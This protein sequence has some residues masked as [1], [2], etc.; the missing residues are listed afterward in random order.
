MDIGCRSVGYDDVRLLLLQ[1]AWKVNSGAIMVPK[2]L[3]GND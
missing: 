3:S 2:K 1:S